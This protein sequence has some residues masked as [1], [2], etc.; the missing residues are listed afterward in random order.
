[1]NILGFLFLLLETHCLLK[2]NL[3]KSFRFIGFVTA[4]K[5]G[6]HL[7]MHLFYLLRMGG[8]RDLGSKSLAVSD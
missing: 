6:R 5:N 8:A 2:S 7:E 4:L 1:M 3:V